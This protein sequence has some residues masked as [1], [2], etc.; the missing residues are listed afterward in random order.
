MMNCPKCDA[1]MYKFECGC[2][3]IVPPI[4]SLE[5]HPEVLQTLRAPRPKNT[6][7][8]NWMNNIK[9]ILEGNHAN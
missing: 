3:W 4:S 7:P 8:V 2:G 6:Q 5:A 1:Q 9:K